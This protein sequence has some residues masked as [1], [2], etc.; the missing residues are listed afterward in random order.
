MDLKLRR[1][2]KKD[3][4]FV[5]KLIKELAIFEREPDAVKITEEEL[6]RD[7]FGKSPAFKVFV[8]E[9]DGEIVGMALFYQRY[10][11]WTGKSIHLED[12]VVSKNYRGKGIGSKLYA[13]VLHYAFEHNFKRVAWEVLDWNKVAIDFYRS[14]GAV[15]F[16]DWRVAQMDEIG[17]SKFVSKTS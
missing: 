10:S 14:T 5:L 13:K 2:E 17:L 3:M 8:A 4:N 7:G 12:L 1:S 6:I 11:T 16:E 15:I 9:L